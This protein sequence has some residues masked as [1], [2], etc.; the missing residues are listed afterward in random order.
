MTP[1]QAVPG[2]SPRLDD[3][4]LAVLRE[5]GADVELDENAILFSPADER[6]DLFVVLDGAVS[7]TVDGVEPQQ[8]LASFGAREFLG[9]LDALAGRRTAAT[10]RMAMPGRVLRIPVERARALMAQEPELSELLLRAFLLRRGLFTDLG[11]GP[12]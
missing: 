2:L 11:I 8:L 9:G 3:A 12:T 5:Y 7:L 6:Y 4:E 1:Y 10:A